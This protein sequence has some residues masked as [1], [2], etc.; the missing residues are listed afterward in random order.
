MDMHPP[1][2]EG[3]HAVSKKMN[4]WRLQDKIFQD[5]I[6]HLQYFSPSTLV[7][8]LFLLRNWDW[9]IESGDNFDVQKINETS[10]NALAPLM[11]LPSDCRQVCYKISKITKNPPAKVSSNEI[12]FLVK[13]TYILWMTVD[14]PQLPCIPISSPSLLHCRYKLHILVQLKN[15]IIWLSSSVHRTEW[16]DGTDV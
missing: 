2:K 13:F 11:Q 3:F 1:I 14:C 9:H 8:A 15:Q 16:Q 7:R 4:R 6:C 10:H 5:P 12:F